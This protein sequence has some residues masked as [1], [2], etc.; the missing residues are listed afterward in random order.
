MILRMSILGQMHS[1]YCHNLQGDPKL[2]EST[3]GIHSLWISLTLVLVFPHNNPRVVCGTYALRP[4]WHRLSQQT[5]RMPPRSHSS[6]SNDKT[7]VKSRIS[8]TPGPAFW[9]LPWLGVPPAGYTSEASKAFLTLRP[10][11]LQSFF[12]ECSAEW[13]PFW[14]WGPG[15]Q[16]CRHFWTC[17]GSPR[18]KSV[19]NH[20]DRRGR[21]RDTQNCRHFWTSCQAGGDAVTLEV[22]VKNPRSRVWGLSNDFRPVTHNP[23]PTPAGASPETPYLESFAWPVDSVDVDLDAVQHL[24]SKIWWRITRTMKQRLGLCWTLAMRK[25]Q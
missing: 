7:Q 9:H 18:F 10:R 15:V 2:S 16:N 17:V 8:Q 20:R 24:G 19:I 4:G 12:P 23:S 1:R 11:S 21:G 6:H 3:R 25:L 5:N 13:F 14:G 22:N